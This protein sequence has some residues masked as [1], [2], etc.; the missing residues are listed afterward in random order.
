MCALHPL[1]K[2]IQSLIQLSLSV[3]FPQGGLLDLGVRG[4]SPAVSPGRLA[5]KEANLVNFCGGGGWGPNWR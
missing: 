5:D 2:F 1:A 3:N 4:P